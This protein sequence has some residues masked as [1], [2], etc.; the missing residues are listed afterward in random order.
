MIAW[1]QLGTERRIQILNQAG[2]RTGIR[3]RAIEKDWWV[4]LALKA[5]F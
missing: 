1:L 4:T 5:I 3:V 2:N